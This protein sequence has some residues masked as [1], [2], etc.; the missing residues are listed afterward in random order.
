MQVHCKT[1]SLALLL[2]EVDV[3]RFDVLRAD[4]P[5]V[6]SNKIPPR[7]GGL[8]LYHIYMYIH[9]NYTIYAYMPRPIG[10]AKQTAGQKEG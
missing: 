7:L 1:N 4:Q 2:D 9:E 3:D 8:H 6:W 10:R 5:L